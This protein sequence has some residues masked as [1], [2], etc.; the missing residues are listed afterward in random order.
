MQEEEKKRK[1]G[2]S[3]VSLRNEEREGH[4][5]APARRAGGKGACGQC[6][7]ATSQG[8]SICI[9]TAVIV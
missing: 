2:G 5:M 3:A 7:S 4:V 8:M 6:M 1:R 9:Q